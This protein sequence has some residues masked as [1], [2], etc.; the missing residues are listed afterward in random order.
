MQLLHIAARKLPLP[1]NKIENTFQNIVMILN[2]SRDEDAVAIRGSRWD[3]RGVYA[4]LDESMRGSAH[5][6]LRESSS[7]SVR[8]SGSS[9]RSAMMRHLCMLLRPFQGIHR[10]SRRRT[11]DCETDPIFLS[12]SQGLW[13]QRLILLDDQP[14]AGIEA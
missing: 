3:Q 13:G 2:D 1:T 12:G 4:F 9:P 10:A 11:L 14:V 5:T 8:A 7:P 6:R